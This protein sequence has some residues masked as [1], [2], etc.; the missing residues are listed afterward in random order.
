MVGA[1]TGRLPA[2]CGQ[3]LPLALWVDAPVHPPTPGDV[4]LLKLGSGSIVCCCCCMGCWPGG[5]ESTRA[6]PQPVP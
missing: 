4:A 1:G 3:E 2:L 5:L 6:R